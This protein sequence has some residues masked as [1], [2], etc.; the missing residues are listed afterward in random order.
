MPSVEFLWFDGC[1][2]H[3]AAR[4]LLGEVLDELAPGTP[5]NEI[6]ASDPAVAEAYRFPGSPTIRIDGE[7]IVPGFE[8][9]GDYT[10]RCRVFWT[11]EGMRGLP[12]REWIEV[13]VRRCVS[14]S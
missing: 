6:N 9:P 1:P 12:S 5:V 13:A 10:P 2:N 14:G 7:D 3:V 11:A 8:D 4:A